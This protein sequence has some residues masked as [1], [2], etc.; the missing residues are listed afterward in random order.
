MDR[1][2][3]R[4]VGR[5]LPDAIGIRNLGVE[6]HRRQRVVGDRLRRTANRARPLLDGGHAVHYR[7]PAGGAALQRCH[8]L[9]Q[10]REHLVIA[11]QTI[12]AIRELR[13]AT[14][15]AVNIERIGDLQHPIGGL[16]IGCL[17]LVGISPIIHRQLLAG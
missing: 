5:A 15:D 2:E 13:F 1:R 7:Q 17:I 16:N 10:V 9:Y 14:P 12:V 4:R 3:A 8:L 11:D 6:R